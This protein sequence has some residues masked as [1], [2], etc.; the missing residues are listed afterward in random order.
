MR[1]QKRSAERNP[2]FPKKSPASTENAHSEHS[3]I[4][5]F[6]EV[7]PDGAVIELIQEAATKSL[8]LFLSDGKTRKIAPEV[9]FRGHVYRAA[10]INHSILL[11]TRFPSKCDGFESTAKLFTEI[12]NTFMSRG[13]AEEVALPATYSSFAS[14]FPACLPAAPCLSISGPQAEARLFLVLLSCMVRHPLPLGEVTR[15]SLCSLPMDLQL[16]L[17]IDQERISRSAWGLLSASN[18][19]RAYIPWKGGLVNVF[20]AKA[21][22]CG[23]KVIK[24]NFG[25]EALQINLTP[26]RGRL[27]VLDGRDQQKISE[28]FQAKFLDYRCRNVMKVRES[29]CDFPELDSSIRILGRILGAP[30]VDA[31]ELQAN[32]APLLR[33]YQEG[34]RASK[35]LDLRCVTVE[36]ILDHCHKEPGKRVHVGTLTDT[37]NRILKGRGERAKFE[38]EVIGGIL[39]G[40]LGFSPERDSEGYY[41]LLDNRVCRYAHQLAYGYDVAAVQEGIAECSH[42]S[43]IFAT[44]EI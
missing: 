39:R 8:S 10:D 26:S 17:L 42:C 1:I 23:A 18:W 7:F 2:N 32:L 36:A 25:D 30:I 19:R 11:A 43:A 33:E 40:Q 4:R 3:P 44:E 15:A 41:I 21:V 16:T 35:W 38:P 22:Y 34:I 37:V 31:P 29:R 20:C 14:W 9:D 5:T 13:F 28:R 24:N 6:G 27:P 12:R